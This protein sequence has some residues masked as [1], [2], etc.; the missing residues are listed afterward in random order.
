ML[1]FGEEE[2]FMA[3]H[4]YTAYNHHIS[5]HK[6]FI[7]KFNSIKKDFEARGAS[8]ETVIEINKHVVE[9]LINHISIEDKAFG[10]FLKKI[11]A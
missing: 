7:E 2:A 5:L 11:S 8:S 1:H 9:W 3:K 10:R 6:E 4:K